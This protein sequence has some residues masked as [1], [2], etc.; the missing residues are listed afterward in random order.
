MKKS[1]KLIMLAILV[2]AAVLPLNVQ[3]A[4]AKSKAIKA[5]KNFLAQDTIPWGTDTYYTAVPTNTCKFALAYI[6]KN[7]VPEL[8]VRSSYVTHI[9]GFSVIFTYKNGKVQPVSNI[10][11][12]GDFYYY[13]K[14]GVFASC[15]LSMGRASYGYCKMSGLST[16][17]KIYE[18]GDVITGDKFY[19]K[20]NNRHSYRKIRQRASLDGGSRMII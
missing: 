11:D 16:K 9:A 12:D 3:A 4:S 15:Y 7:S 6:D 18:T 1:R 17:A 2:L 19:F 20:A 5:Y 14:K 10:Q 8:V 13:K